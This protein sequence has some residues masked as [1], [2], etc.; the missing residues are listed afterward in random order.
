[1]DII[2]KKLE[3]A[4]FYANIGWLVVPCY[5]LTEGGSCTCAKGA[6]CDSPGKH[7]RLT[8]WQ[9]KASKDELVVTD[10]FTKWPGS[11]LGVRLGP[12]SDLIDIEYDSEEGKATAL[13]LLAEVKTPSFRSKRSVH[14]LFAFPPSLAISKAVVKWRGLEIRFGTEKKGAQ[15][16]FPPSR[17]ASGVA[18]EWITHPSQVG[19]ADAPEWLSKALAGDSASDD[20]S[21]TF[22]MVDTTSTL[23]SH[24]GANDGERNK[25]LCQLVGRYIATN[26]ANA[27]LVDQALAW[28][29]RCTP[30]IAQAEVLKVIANLSQKDTAEQGK[31]SA[32]TTP[33]K[34][35]EIAAR[36]YS[37]IDSQP[38]EW[39][40]HD[41]IAIGKLSLLAGQPGLGKTFS[42]IDI[43][44][45]V[46]TGSMFCDGAKPPLGQ[47]GILTAEDGAGDTIR[48]RLDACGAN[49]A[50]VFHIDGVRGKDKT[51]FLSLKDHLS[52]LEAF[53]ESKP[54]LRLF[55]LDPI[56]AFMGSGCDSHVNASVRSVLG[57]LCE[58]A[59][60]RRVALLG[61]THLSK[62]QAKAINAIIG[63]IAFV[64]AA[65][66]AYLVAQD[67][68]D[69]KQR[70]F[71]PIKNNLASCTGLSFTIE[72][73]RCVWS[74]DA[75]LVSADDIGEEDETPRA[76]AKQWLESKLEKSSMPAKWILAES[77]KDGISEKTLRR[78]GKEIGVIHERVG[79]S[80]SWRLPTTTKTELEASEWIVS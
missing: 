52:E 50:N 71:L 70:L 6:A 38:V 73:G 49:V 21:M 39:L 20:G 55:I 41:R 69:E 26:G 35:R 22:E 40:W 68:D 61:I 25:T 74:S 60:R 51:E 75:V 57:P 30:P 36:P 8:Q 10:W 42:A 33:S 58:L 28:A 31:A 59:E 23:E 45:K 3:E 47:V 46:S 18:Y 17:H 78:A 29:S 32:A 54:D 80:W 11:N 16:I 15:S 13:E 77:R 19:I 44:S 37:T 63:S 43:A 48:P 2:S 66:S 1:M 62:G 56:S 79:D 5:G 76:E 65:R 7:P 64:A 72:E 9:D 27:A 12:A 24:P 34:S 14:H 67:P 53:F 4:K